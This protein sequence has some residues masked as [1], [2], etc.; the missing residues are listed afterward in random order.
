[1]KR[2]QRDGKLRRYVVFTAN[3]YGGEDPWEVYAPNEE[4]AV[5]AVGAH[6]VVRALEIKEE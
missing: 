5:L 4:V 6:R 3:S 1:M 2:Q